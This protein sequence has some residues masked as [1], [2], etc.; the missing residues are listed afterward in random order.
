VTDWVDA[1]RR[2]AES[3]TAGAHPA[4]PA[5]GGSAADGPAAG[6]SGDCRWCPLCQAAAVLR[7]ERPEVTEALADVLTVS[8]QALRS[9]AESAAARAA[10]SAAESAAAPGAEPDAE[11][12]AGGSA[13]PAP[14]GADVPPPAVQRIELG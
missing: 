1:A 6:A 13:A 2:L 12:G 4:A 3:L 11:P 8:A 7:G 5:A 9:F 14:T 10:D